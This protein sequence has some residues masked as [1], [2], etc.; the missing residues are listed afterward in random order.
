MAAGKAWTLLPY[1][2]RQTTRDSRDWAESDSH[3]ARHSHLYKLPAELLGMIHERLTPEDSFALALTCTRFYYSSILADVQRDLKATK[4][5]HF[6]TLCMFED[7]GDIDEYCCR[8]CLSTHPS[9]AFSQD[10]LE[11]RHT[12]RYCLKTKDSLISNNEWV[13]FSK[14]QGE[15]NRLK[16]PK[17]LLPR[18]SMLTRLF[19]SP[20]TTML[21]GYKLFP[22]REP[23]SKSHFE[24]VCKKINLPLC[25]HMRLGDKGFTDMFV[26]ELYT[27]ER[28]SKQEWA[29]L[30]ENDYQSY[31]CKHCKA[32]AVIT[33]IF[34]TSRVGIR[35]WCA[36]IIQRPLGRLLSPLEPAWLAHASASRNIAFNG[37]HHEALD[38]WF[39]AYW[40]PTNRDTR[41]TIEYPQVDGDIFTP[42][43]LP[44]SSWMARLG[45][46]AC[47]FVCGCVP[48][49][50]HRKFGPAHEVNRAGTYEKISKALR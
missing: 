10:E 33:Q 9:S 22:L 11:K 43:A 1:L 13:S 34:N 45:V 12:E 28:R 41:N 46:K 39:K 30:V 17:T 26:P 21:T 37:N 36:V 40:T 49:A 50:V 31:K 23:M 48:E 2:S 6:V 3:N 19:S 29:T 38:K 27:G 7:V 5:G 24:E 18:T 25:Q 14:I 8:G 47:L 35:N 4:I 32:I 16:E 15:V 44:E 20:M 42:I